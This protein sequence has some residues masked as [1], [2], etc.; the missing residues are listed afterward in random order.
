MPASDPEIER[1]AGLYTG[2]SINHFTN[3]APCG[4]LG[5]LFLFRTGLANAKRFTRSLYRWK[6]ASAC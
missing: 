1:I 3:I 4:T 5:T 2:L 6:F